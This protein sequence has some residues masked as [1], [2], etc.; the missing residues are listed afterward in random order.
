LF[1]HIPKCLQSHSE[2]AVVGYILTQSQ[3]AVG[4]YIGQD[5]N[6]VEPLLK[7]LYTSVETA[8]IRPAPPVAQIAVFVE[9]RAFVIKPVYHLMSHYSS[10]G[11]IIEG[12]IGIHIKKR[13]LQYARRKTYF[14]DGYVIIGVY[15]LWIHIPFRRIN[16]FFEFAFN[17]VIPKKT[18]YRSIV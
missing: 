9:L 18:I 10:D 3:L 12:V 16:R 1:H 2:S 6:A 5:L 15:I 4:L 17:R 8:C 11:S 13:I 7:Y 14:V